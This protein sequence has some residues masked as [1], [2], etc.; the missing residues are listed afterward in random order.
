MFGFGF[1][2]WVVVSERWWSEVRVWRVYESWMECGE[3]G[4]DRNPGLVV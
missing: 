4:S 1:A 2:L 3:T